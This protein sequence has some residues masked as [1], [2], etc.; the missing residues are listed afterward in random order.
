MPDNGE[1]NNQEHSQRKILSG[2]AKQIIDH[3]IGNGEYKL[4]E[5][6]MEPHIM[7]P[8]TNPD[9]YSQVRHER[10]FTVISD[11]LTGEQWCSLCTD[12]GV[13]LLLCATCRVGVCMTSLGVSTGCIK[14]D[15]VVNEDTFI[16]HCP[17]CPASRQCV[18]L[19]LR[20]AR[21]CNSD[22][23]W[24]RYDPPVLIVSLDLD[25]TKAKFAQLLYTRLLMA[26]LGDE[27][28]VCNFTYPSRLRFLTV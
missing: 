20:D 25:P 1:A 13:T 11:S 21:P 12:F 22:D 9:D 8:S 19:P 5:K 6:E 4:R 14:W 18:Q 27:D 24:Y 10:S 17:F 26:Y 28:M 23:L 16:Y 15:S 2:R 7:A 3:A